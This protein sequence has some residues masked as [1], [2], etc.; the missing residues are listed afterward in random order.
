L[1]QI[2]RALSPGFQES[3]VSR[4]AHA[5]TILLL[6]A[7]GEQHTLGLVILSEFFQREGWHLLGGPA[8][9]EHDAVDIVRGEWVDVAGFSVGSSN[10]LDELSAYIRGVRRAS[11]NRYLAVMVGGPLFLQRPELVTRVGADC[12]AEDAPSAVRQ[13]RGFLTLRAAAD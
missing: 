7:P 3:A 8:S 13:A 9:G 11:R 6:P 2:V 10:H 5:D 1:Q 4:S 12:T